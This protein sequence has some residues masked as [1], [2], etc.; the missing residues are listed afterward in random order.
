[1]N[2]T[3]MNTPNPDAPDA[4]K[5][6]SEESVNYIF[7]IFTGLIP[8]NVYKYKIRSI[9]KIH[10]VE[11]KV[12]IHLSKHSKTTGAIDKYTPYF[13]I[14]SRFGKYGSDEEYHDDILYTS[15]MLNTSELNHE[16]IRDVLRVIHETLP[17][18]I[19]DDNRNRLCL[20]RFEGFATTFLSGEECCVCI[21][22]T[23]CKTNCGHPVCLVCWGRLQNKYT[24]FYCPICRSS[25]EY[26][27][28]CR[29]H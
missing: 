11:V 16:C 18:L 1:M 27:M 23:T 12:F 22:K 7:K 28:N 26:K 8:E 24:L 25:V 20:P 6:P 10:D 13:E 9:Q 29:D 21:E 15:P 19:I 2:E 4:D 17:I 3:N 5:M 14:L